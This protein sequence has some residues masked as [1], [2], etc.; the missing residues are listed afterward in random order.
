MGLRFQ[1]IALIACVL[2]LAGAIVGCGG[3]D[4]DGEASD[5]DGEGVLSEGSRPVR[6]D[7]EKKSSVGRI[8][9]SDA[10]APG[11]IGVLGG[12][13]ARDTG[14]AHSGDASLKV[15]TTGSAAGEGATIN[16]PS[17]RVTPNQ[18]LHRVGLDPR[19]EGREP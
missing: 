12:S 1:Q 2:G 14:R 13:A 7:F 16:A 18:H 19:P 15:D 6:Y 5:S 3:D 10:T 17:I 11:W 8:G 9:G 4:D